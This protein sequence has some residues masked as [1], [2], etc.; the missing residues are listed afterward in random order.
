MRGRESLFTFLRD[1]LLPFAVVAFLVLII[2]MLAH[3]DT[4]T[5][6]F[7][8]LQPRL[9]KVSALSNCGATDIND[10]GD[11]VGTCSDIE[12]QSH[13]WMLADGRYREIDVEKIGARL[14]RNITFT[15]VYK[16]VSTIL[17]A[18]ITPQGIN[19]YGAIT[20]WYNEPYEGGYRLVSF[21]RNGGTVTEI[22]VSGARL[23]EVT[24]I[25]DAG[26]VVG[27]YLGMDGNY[28]G[29]KYVNGTYLSISV[30]WTANAGANDINN[31]GV[32]V[33]VSGTGQHA[34]ILDSNGVRQLDI[35]GAALTSVGGLNDLGAIVGV[36]SNDPYASTI[37]GYLLQ[38]GIVTVF[39]MA[40]ALVTA[41][42]AVN[43]RGSVVGYVAANKSNGTCC[44]D[45]AFLAERR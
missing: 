24:G 22:S 35:L 37:H 41:P 30:P 44:D 7:T 20:G 25:D 2:A 45:F 13:A 31:V 5:Y 34:F 19:N 8:L 4:L 6:T 26:D 16:G 36:Y 21:V 9:S 1:N 39:D 33:G 27:D 12:G 11:I 42:F 29:F 32:I 40:G 15:Y 23:T 43:N 3:A 38:N 14:G 18:T 10:S 17:H 28:Y